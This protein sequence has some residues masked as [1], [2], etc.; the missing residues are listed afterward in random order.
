[1]FKY[2]EMNDSTAFGSAKGSPL[3]SPT[4]KEEDSP[5]MKAPFTIEMKH[6]GLSPARAKTNLM[7]MLATRSKYSAKEFMR[8]MSTPQPE[9]FAKTKKIE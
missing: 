9:H 7:K 3:S 4:M 8:R 1:M 5:C 2:K 6:S